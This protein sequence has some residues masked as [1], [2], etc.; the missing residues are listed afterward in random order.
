MIDM[1]EGVIDAFEKCQYKEL[2]E[3]HQ[4]IRSNAGAGNNWAVGHHRYGPEFRGDIME[5]IR[6]EAEH[7]DALQSFFLC[8]SMGGGTGSGLG[9][10]VLSQLAD[11]YPDIY[12]F[13]T[14]VFPGEDDD[15]VTAPY[16]STLA[17][18]ELDKYAD[19]VLPVD[20]DALFRV[21]T[22]LDKL[23]SKGKTTQVTDANAKSKSFDTINRIITNMLLNLTSSMRFHGSMN[24]DLSEIA[25]N[26]VPFSKLKYLT[27]SMAPLYQHADIAL[28]VRSVD[29]MFQDAFQ[30]DCH[31]MSTSPQSHLYLS[32]ALLARGNCD[33]S[34]IH[35]NI[36]KLRKQ[37]NFVSWN[38]DGWKT[39][40][41]SVPP[42]KQN[43]S[44]LVLANN[45][46]IAEPFAQVHSRFTKLFRRK[47]HLHHYEEYMD[48][49]SISE[50]SDS[51]RD[52]VKGYESLQ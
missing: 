11:E 23:S 30:K 28:E 46:C 17:L 25:T 29:Q 41:C 49:S 38:R 31:L 42:A 52:I 6:R 44:L 19:C 13:C 26:L 39:G 2:F 12:K 36:E 10:Y 45:T 8:H 3:E 15:V 37:L 33:I 9:T 43:C 22:K 48:V 34:D 35:A 14:I 1:E 27:T 47:A 20:N 7:C 18:A 50:A 21:Q 16:N 5:S 32:A 40:L 24:V 4:K 51:V